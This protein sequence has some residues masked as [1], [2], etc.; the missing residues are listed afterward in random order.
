VA[1]R[2]ASRLTEPLN[3]ARVYAILRKILLANAPDRPEMR[4]IAWAY[5][6]W[7]AAPLRKLDLLNYVRYTAQ[8]YPRYRQP[9]RG[10]ASPA[11]KPPPSYTVM[12]LQTSAP[13][14]FRA[15]QKRDW[16][17]AHN[18]LIQTAL[19]LKVYRQQHGR[20]PD[21]LAGLPWPSQEDP[22]SGKPF[23][24]QRQGAG[25]RL[26]SLGPDLK[27]NKGTPMP[28]KG[29]ETRWGDGDIVWVSR[30]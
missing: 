11:E 20:Y 8:V 18:G 29:G 24:Y 27:D 1:S 30:R 3:L 13:V 22:F 19:A 10:I 9:Y 2:S 21:K 15:A 5:C 6:S 23:V 26:Y 25:F 28:R 12:L 4:L 7:A 17:M 14:F 16:A